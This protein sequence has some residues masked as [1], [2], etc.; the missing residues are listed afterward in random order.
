MCASKECC[1]NMVERIVENRTFISA[2]II[3]MFTCRRVCCKKIPTDG[4]GWGYRFLLASEK[5]REKNQLSV[6]RNVRRSEKWKPVI[7]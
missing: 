6:L 2:R 5:Y 7:I 4:A 3:E 1:N